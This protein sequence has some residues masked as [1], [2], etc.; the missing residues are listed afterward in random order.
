MYKVN[1]IVVTSLDNVL[2]IQ[3]NL[4]NY[5]K[6]GIHENM[7]FHFEEV[8]PQIVDLVTVIDSFLIIIKDERGKGLKF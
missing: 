1:L 2:K 7:L 3:P 5:G 4:L 8:N 6:K